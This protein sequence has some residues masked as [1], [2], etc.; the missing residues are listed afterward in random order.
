MQSI[1]QFS[2]VVAGAGRPIYFPDPFSQPMPYPAPGY[3]SWPNEF[4]DVDIPICP[5]DPYLPLEA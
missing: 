5:T 3:P 2:Q 1:E 4:P